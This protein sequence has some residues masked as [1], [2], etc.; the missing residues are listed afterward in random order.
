MRNKWFFYRFDKESMLL[1]APK[2]IRNSFG[3]TFTRQTEIR[4]NA[5]EFEDMLKG[6]YSQPQII[7]IPDELDPEIPRMIF[8]SKHGF[9]QIIA[10]QVNITLNV[11]YSPD[12][13]IDISK[14]REYLLKRVQILFDLLEKLQDV[15]LYFCGLTTV[16]RLPAIVDEDS[17]LNFLTKLCLNKEEAEDIY[18][19][20]VKI[21]KVVSER[22]FSNITSKNYRLWKIDTTDPQS[23]PRLSRKGS[24]E[25]GIEIVGDFNDRYMF[26][27]KK[28][29]FSNQDIVHEIIEQGICEIE[30]AIKRIKGL[31]L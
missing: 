18:D 6:D 28:D 11:K 1:E 19:I 25:H 30:K 29:Y 8:T 24:F 21:A 31:K 10:S 13:Q 9:S 4:R 22:F 27:E 2:Y 3:V 7:S 12:W 15:N 5:N 17:V 16:T 14:G 26:N 23:V 20:H